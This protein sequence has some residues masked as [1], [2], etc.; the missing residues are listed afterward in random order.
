MAEKTLTGM[1][2]RAALWLG[3]AAAAVAGAMAYSMREVPMKV[4]VATVTRGPVTETVAAITTG[5]VTAPLASKVSAAGVG[6]VSAVHVN[7][8]D[9]VPEGGLLMEL[10]HAELDAQ[11]ALAQAN[12]SV[13]ES[14]ASQARIAAQT[15]REI[16]EIELRRA[17]SA[18]E[19]AQSDFNR[20]KALTEKQA[21]SQSDYDK[22]S[23]ALKTA[24]D[25]RAAAEAGQRE[26]LVRDEDVRI[27]AANI[28]QLKAALTAA[29][30]MRDKAFVRAPF[31]GVVA[32]KLLQVG[33]AVVMGMP[34]A[35]LV[36][37]GGAYI[38]APF[39]EANLEALKV[40]QTAEIEI[41]SCPG[42]T[43]KGTLTYIS[44]VVTMME[45]LSRSLLCKISID[46]GA[47]MFRPGMSA[48]V[49]IITDRKED[50]PFVPSEALVRDKYAFVVRDGRAEQREVETG[51]GNWDQREILG[52]LA[53]GDTIITSISVKGLADGSKIEIVEA[54]DD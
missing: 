48:D 34:V 37:A 25:A 26:A 50:V 35:Y 45:Q 52:G 9:A 30:A 15:A 36:Q 51:I 21:I 7:E 31:A 5:S 17:S 39:D 1:I 42:R 53:V 46:E 54:L 6:T 41:D 11:V 18:L 13:G 14:R 24:Q 4:T 44:P 38:E 28:E 47:E 29:E 16:S 23:L 40:G 2:V 22:A 19:M 3:L 8:G 10:N 49:T 12:L 20:I 43:F 27:A 33:E 32:K